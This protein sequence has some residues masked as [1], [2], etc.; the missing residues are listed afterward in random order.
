[1]N[2]IGKRPFLIILALLCLIWLVYNVL[3]L[4][5]ESEV[6]DLPVK[7]LTV[8]EA[9]D[10]S[11]AL[12]HPDFIKEEYVSHIPEGVNLS[13]EA[14]ANASSFAQSYTPRKVIDGKTDG[15]SYWE[16]SPD[17]YPNV[18]T[19]DLKAIH[20]I[21]AVR[22]M[23]NPAGIWSE[24]EQTFDI[25]TSVDGTTFTPWVEAATYTFSPDTG[26]E[27]IVELEAIDAR[28]VRLTF[29]SNTGGSGAQI[30]EFE[31]YGK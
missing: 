13:K 23:L 3:H 4:M 12:E 25:Q 6:Y 8:I 30:A 5:N 27:V 17:S 16:A 1:M 31:V 24:R 26:N 10:Q 20:S 22:L 21:H 2:N 29:T 19:L 15:V 18:I 11:D 9:I 28:Y 7:N 14:E